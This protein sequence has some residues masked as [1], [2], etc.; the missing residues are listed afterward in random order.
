MGQP[1]QSTYSCL[2]RPVSLT[3]SSSV[4]GIVDL[5][6]KIT[7]VCT[8]V[9]VPGTRIFFL[10]SLEELFLN[11]YI[12]SLQKRSE[13][14][15]KNKSYLQKGVSHLTFSSWWGDKTEGPDFL[16]SSPY[17]LVRLRR[18]WPNSFLSDYILLTSRSPAVP[19]VCSIY[20]H[21]LSLNALL[22]SSVLF[23]QMLCFTCHNSPLWN[24]GGGG[25]L[26]PRWSLLGPTSLVYFA[27]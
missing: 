6:P 19:T 12:P 23:K 25:H 9:S 18:P 27:I 24:K 2:I 14:I 1:A 11:S 3:R 15:I 22:S 10:P 13:T 16:E 7:K 26:T 4:R 8:S 21:F 17:P 20:C 5:Q